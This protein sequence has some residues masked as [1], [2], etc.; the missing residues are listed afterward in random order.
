MV[1]KGGARPAADALQP[2]KRKRWP[3]DLIM[4]GPELVKFAL[5]VVPPLVDRLLDGAGWTR[6]DVDMYLMHQATSFMLDHLRNR[7]DLRAGSRADGACEDYGNTVSSTLPMLIRDLR[8]DGRLRP[9]QA[10]A[11]GRLRRGALL[12]RLRMDRDLGGPAKSRHLAKGGLRTGH[13]A[14]E[15]RGE[16]AA[17]IVDRDA[18]AED[19]GKCQEER[20]S[21][22]DYPVAR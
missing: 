16:P 17:G 15:S 9:G 10:D 12:G 20:S 11:A 22:V 7:L 5:D 14:T 8:D 13:N 3:S 19:P 18:E 2:R 1:T 4:D 21:H 6:D